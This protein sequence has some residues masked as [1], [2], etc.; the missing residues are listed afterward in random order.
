MPDDNLLQR[1]IVAGQETRNY[2]SSF[3]DIIRSEYSNAFH[4]FVDSRYQ[5][6]IEKVVVLCMPSVYF[7]FYGQL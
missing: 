7:V 5:L 1:L 6:S 4:T 2:A 3:H